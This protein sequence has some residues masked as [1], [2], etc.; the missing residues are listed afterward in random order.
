[1]VKQKE[2][3][4]ND[5]FHALADP[6]RR[7][8]LKM[9]S[10]KDCQA[11]ELAQAFEMSFPAVSKHLKVLEKAQFIRRKVNGRIH[12][13]YFEEK[14]MKE[15]YH[16]VKFYEKFWLQNLSNLDDFLNKKGRQE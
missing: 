4:I 12:R 6:T 15:V 11:T 5:I 8:I 14:T 16:W 1:M 7:K 10:E 13:F 2:Q 9:L 3:H